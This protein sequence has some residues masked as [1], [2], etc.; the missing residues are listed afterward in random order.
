MIKARVAET[1]IK[2]LFQVCGY[3]VFEHGMERSMP[4]ITGRLNTD[5]SEV[6]L[7]IRKMPDFVVQSPPPESCLNYIE[8]K[9]RKNG[10]F[11]S[12]NDNIENYPYKNAWF[13]IVSKSEFRCISYQQIMEGEKINGS[14]DFLLE[15][16]SVFKLDK[17]LVQLYLDYSKT[18]F[19]GVE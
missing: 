14:D 18:F 11:P 15:N 2:E 16:S 1:I 3:K 8:V 10:R 19:E 4:V 13:I 5:N 12:K 17:S 6:A 9:Y 7:Q